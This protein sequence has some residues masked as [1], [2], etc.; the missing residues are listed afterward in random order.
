MTDYVRFPATR[1]EMLAIAEGFRQRCNMPGV[2]G[3]I[4]GTHI[5]IPAPKSAHR[6]SYI[7]RKGYSS[8]VLQVICDSQLQ[9]LDVYT[10]WPGSVHDSRVYRHSPV[11]AKIEEL[12]DEFHLLG[13]SAYQLS[14]SMLVPFRDD[15][16]LD[17]RQKNFNSCHSST[18]VDIERAIGLLKC[19][20]RRLKYLDMLL[21]EEIPSI[22]GSCCVLHNFI[23]LHET[24]EFTDSFWTDDIQPTNDLSAPCTRSNKVEGEEKRKRIAEVLGQ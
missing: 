6:S 5:G 12:P 22:I 23:L 21:E 16:H 11:A 2:V 19:K 4:D 8:I 18:R 20:F 3:A 7:N 15:G 14:K 10:G 9:F 13:D 17:D 1:A 24:V